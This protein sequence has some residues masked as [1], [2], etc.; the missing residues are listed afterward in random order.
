MSPEEKREQ[1]VRL[2]VELE[3]AEEE[4]NHCR[5]AAN[6]KSDLLGQLAEWLR[7]SPE[8]HIYWTGGSTHHGFDVKPLPEK[9][10]KVLA[11]KDLVGLADEIRKAQRRVYDLQTRLERL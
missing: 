6:A 11:F 5:E 10:V 3:E 8:V 2:R 9:Y 1:K 4:L 7:T